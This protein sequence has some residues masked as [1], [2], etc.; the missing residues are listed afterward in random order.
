M[1]SEIKGCLVSEQWL[2]DLREKRKKRELLASPNASVLMELSFRVAGP[3]EIFPSVELP[4]LTCSE[5]KEGCIQ[6]SCNQ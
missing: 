3:S 6:Q 5:R 4:S 2:A 1:G